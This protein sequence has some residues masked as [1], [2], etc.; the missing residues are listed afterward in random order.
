MVDNYM[1]MLLKWKTFQKSRK[2]IRFFFAILEN[3]HS[4]ADTFVYYKRTF[5]RKNFIR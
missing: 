2:N 3:I 1:Y 4:F 5:Y